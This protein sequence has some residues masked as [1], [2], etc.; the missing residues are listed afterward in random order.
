MKTLTL[1]FHER[2]LIND[3]SIKRFGSL[4]KNICGGLIIVQF[5]ISEYFVP[6]QCRSKHWN[7]LKAT[8]YQISLFDWKIEVGS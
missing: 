7:I 8:L 5:S 3:F 6:W 1:A 4:V 2:T